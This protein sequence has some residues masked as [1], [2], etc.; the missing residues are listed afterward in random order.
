MLASIG[1]RFSHA[2]GISRVRVPSCSSLPRVSG[3]HGDS[4]TATG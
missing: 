3:R 2:R 4:V 1:L